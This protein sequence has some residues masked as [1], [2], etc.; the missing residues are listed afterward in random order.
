M[1]NSLDD[2]VSG[3][4]RVLDGAVLLA[5]MLTVSDELK[6]GWLVVFIFKNV[7]SLLLPHRATT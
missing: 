5:P 6:P 7:L 2:V 4:L 1:A 3:A